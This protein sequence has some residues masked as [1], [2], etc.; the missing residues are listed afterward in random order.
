M[1]YGQWVSFTVRVKG[2]A[3]RADLANLIWGKF[4][5][6]DDKDSEIDIAAVN[7]IKFENNNTYSNIIASCGRSDAASGTEGSFY[8]CIDGKAP[9]DPD[10]KVCKISWDCPWGTK[11][12]TFAASDFDPDK[13]VVSIIG[14]S[15][16]GGSIG[17]LTVVVA[18]IS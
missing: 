11:T 1:A 8:I 14:G 2:F 10:Y 12:N 7:N 16:Y 17:M 9:D 3:G 13:Y 4:Y 18:D 15:T 5:K 6:Y